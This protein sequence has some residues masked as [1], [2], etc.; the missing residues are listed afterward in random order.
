MLKCASF[1]AGVGGI[2]IGFHNAGFATVYANE[3]DSYAAETL[4]LNLP[5][6]VDKRD[7]NHVD[8]K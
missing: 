8:E 6:K 3:F 2:D 5:I 7:V 4:E 1:F